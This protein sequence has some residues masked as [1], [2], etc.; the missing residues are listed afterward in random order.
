MICGLLYGILIA[1]I[2][3]GL[4]AS[5]EHSMILLY[6]I[7]MPTIWLAQK[8]PTVISEEM[9]LSFIAGIN[10]LLFF[11]IIYGGAKGIGRLRKKA[12][13]Q[14]PEPMPLTRHGSS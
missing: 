7:L 2:Q 11:S 10:V 5:G 13:N 9:P 6:W 3:L 1:A 14:S 12:P 8:M 4:V